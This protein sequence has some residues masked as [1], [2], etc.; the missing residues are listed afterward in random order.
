ML[1]LQEENFPFVQASVPVPYGFVITN[2]SYRSVFNT[3]HPHLVQPFGKINILSNNDKQKKNFLVK[4]S[5]KIPYISEVNDINDLFPSKLVSKSNGFY[6]MRFEIG[7]VYNRPYSKIKQTFPASLGGS[8]ISRKA[9][10][11]YKITNSRITISKRIVTRNIKTL[12]NH[13]K[14]LVKE[15]NRVYLMYCIHN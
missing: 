14:H 11:V 1:K 6:T 13:C 7:K 3:G 9:G 15:C 2:T 8:K 10:Y 12:E 5:S 4:E